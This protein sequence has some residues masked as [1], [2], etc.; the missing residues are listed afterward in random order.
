MR[1]AL[2]TVYTGKRWKAKVD[3]MN[4]DQV[5]AIYRNLQTQNKL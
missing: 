3:K 1:A 4:D 5:V 2:K